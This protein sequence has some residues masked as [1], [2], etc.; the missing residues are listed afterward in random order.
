M[1]KIE[2]WEHVLKWEIKTLL[3]IVILGQIMILKWLGTL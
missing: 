1:K 2:V 3:Q